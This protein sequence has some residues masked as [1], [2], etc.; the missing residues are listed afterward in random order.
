VGGRLWCNPSNPKTPTGFRLM[1]TATGYRAY[2]THC[3]GPV[4]G[5]SYKEALKKA[6][7]IR[8][9]VADGKDAVGDEQAARER[10][11]SSKVVLTRDVFEYYLEVHRT[12]LDH[13]TVQAY[14]Q[15][16][17]AIP[18]SLLQEPAENVTPAMFRKLIRQATDAPVMQNWHVLMSDEIRAM[19]KALEVIGPTMPR[20]GR[21][22]MASV[23]IALLVGTRLGE[24]KQTAPNRS[25]GLLFRSTPRRSLPLKD[26]RQ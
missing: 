7:T 22:F 1:V 24:N 15:T 14:E 12:K 18:H 8:G 19:W 20:R 5:L 10:K 6:E 25:L 3:I 21:V 17:D 4:E 16:R 9:L 13:K 11:R 26:G 2:Y 23:R